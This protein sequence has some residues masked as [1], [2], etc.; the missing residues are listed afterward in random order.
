M[1]QAKIN[2]PDYYKDRTGRTLYETIDIID[3]FSLNFSLG[4]AIKYIIR[5]GLKDGEPTHEALEKA[6][7]YLEHEIQRLKREAGEAS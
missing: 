5:A 4:N 6:V 2:H 3:M 7:W 1:T